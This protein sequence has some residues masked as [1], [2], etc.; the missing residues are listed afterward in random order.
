MATTGSD[1]T[2]AR[3]LLVVV[4]VAIALRAAAAWLT[5]DIPGDGPSRAGIAYRWSLSPKLIRSGVW[6][7]GFTYLA[8]S[9]CMLIPNPRIAPRLLNVI[10]GSASI[11]LLYVVTRRLYG[12]AVGL[13][14][15]ALLAI[16]PLHVGLSASSLTE[17]GLVF[18]MLAVLCL[19]CGGS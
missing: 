13:S 2:V 6:L 7:P 4:V 16:L 1:P 9:V 5:I 3:T 19:W 17:A 10:L 15:A 12:N 11:P 8:G 18:G 14:A